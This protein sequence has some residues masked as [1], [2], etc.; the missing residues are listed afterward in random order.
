M[1]EQQQKWEGLFRG[2]VLSATIAKHVSFITSADTRAQGLILLNA[3]LV[4]LAINGMR[5]DALRT[6]AILCILTA[7]LTITLC[8]FCLY[9]KRLRSKRK[10][11]NILHYVEFSALSEEVFLSEMKE[12][13]SDK[14]KLAEAAVRDLYHLGSRIVAPKYLFLRFAYLVFLV[15]QLLAAFLALAATA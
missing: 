7:L 13:F 1:K 8:I 3:A 9:P 2:S 10:D 14:E 4:P 6:A 15:G 12:L 11:G 5:T